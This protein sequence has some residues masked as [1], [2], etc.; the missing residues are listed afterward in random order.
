MKNNQNYYYKKMPDVNFGV[1]IILRSDLSYGE[2]LHRHW[3][4][5]MQLFFFLSGSAVLECENDSF[6]VIKG[7]I[8]VINS[9]ELHYVKS[10]SNNLKFYVIRVNLPFLFS[11][12]VDSCQ[13]KFFTPLSQNRITFH[14]LIHQDDQIIMCVKEMVKEY[15]SRTMGYELAVKSLIYRLIV[16]LLRSHVEKI[17]SPKELTARVNNLKRFDTIL[18][19]IDNDYADKITVKELAKSA[20]ITVYYFCRIFKE[21]TG[22][23]FTSYLNEIRLEKSIDFLLEGK[24]NITEIALKTGFDSVNYYSR[25]FRKHYHISPKKFRDN[26]TKRFRI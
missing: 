13:A 19:K 12:Q 24:L 18:K 1:D 16:L 26:H 25:L 10:L 23:T 11:N 3:H 15:N 17:L 21:L 4:E 20:N 8:A 5:Q 14:T 2:E 6:H 7:E 22:K 9:N